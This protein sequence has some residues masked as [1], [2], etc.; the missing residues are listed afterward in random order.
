MDMVKILGQA[1]I[2]AL[3]D[4]HDVSMDESDGESDGDNLPASC[5]QAV[6]DAVSNL[7]KRLDLGWSSVMGWPKCIVLVL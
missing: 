6:K 7:I 1:A 5:I 4:D 2:A 3:S